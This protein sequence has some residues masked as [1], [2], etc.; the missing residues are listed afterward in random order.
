MAIF[1]KYGN[2]ADKH[3]VRAIK[4]SGAA[5][6]IAALYIKTS[7]GLVKIYEAVRSCFSGE[8]WR[9][10]KPWRYDDKWKYPKAT[11]KYLKENGLD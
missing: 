3:G 6:S 9:Y 5:E 7:S 4:R 8:T 1:S 11:R 2:T 10:D